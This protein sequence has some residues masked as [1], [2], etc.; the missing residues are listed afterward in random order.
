MYVSCC[1][2]YD[3]L[4][5]TVNSGGVVF[6]ALFSSSA[7]LSSH[8]AAAVIKIASSRMATQSERLGYELG[9]WLG[10]HTP[11]VYYY[12]HGSPL[13]ESSN[14]FQNR[15]A[16][17]RAAAAL[18][19]VLMLDLILRN[20][21]RLPCRQLGWRGNYANLLIADKVTS[22]NMDALHEES[23][24]ARSYA[25]QVTRFLQKE[26][27]DSASGRTV[28]LISEPSCQSSDVFDEFS[29]KLVKKETVN[30]D[31]SGDF[32]V[33]A[34]DSGVPRRPP[35][36]KRAKDHERY[37][38]LVELLLNNVGY[39]SNLLYE[40]SGGRLGH[41][42]PGEATSISDSCS[43]LD[44]TDMAA[45]VHEFRGGFR[46]ALR[47]LQSFHLFLLTL[48]QKL[49]GLLR[50]FLSIISKSSGESDRDDTGTLDSP[51]HS[52]GFGYSTPSP[53]CKQHIANVES[54]DSTLQKATMTSSSPGSPG[55]ESVSPISHENWNRRYFKGSEEPSHSLRLTMKLRDFH[56]FAKVRNFL[57]VTTLC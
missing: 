23:S 24:A 11:Q 7:D 39:S 12:V 17:V 27:S 26:R 32:R 36:G 18:G 10:V 45:V 13:L 9:K 48:Y 31:S 50:V 19:R 22:E 25:P 43:S 14:A 51:S 6:F 54:S 34:I 46:A 41:P 29:N 2:T 55:S 30:N 47:D 16:A 15:E 44:D 33:V 21:D 40:I 28:P 20:E 57:K 49:D 53:A 3:L 38:K 37:P 5:V 8:E 52:A 42:E 4:Q 35:A 1:N 56:K